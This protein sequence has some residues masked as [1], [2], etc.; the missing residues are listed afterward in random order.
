MGAFG[1]PGHGLAQS[2]SAFGSGVRPG[3]ERKA[4]VENVL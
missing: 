4:G 2:P 1:R 3:G